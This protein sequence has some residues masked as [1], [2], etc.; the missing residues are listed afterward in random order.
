MARSPLR[1]LVRRSLALPGAV[2]DAVRALGDP[3]PAPAPPMLERLRA[4]VARVAGDDPT[5]PLAATYAEV[6]VY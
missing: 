1:S 5:P 4:L 6:R 3:R 2:L